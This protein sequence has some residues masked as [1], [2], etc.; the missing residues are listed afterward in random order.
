MHLKINRAASG[1]SKMCSSLLCSPTFEAA[2]KPVSCDAVYRTSS[3]N[4]L[5]PIIQIRTVLVS[6]GVTC[7][8]KLRSACLCSNRNDSA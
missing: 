2:S 5:M 6:D 4:D 8:L 3:K 7:G 1:S